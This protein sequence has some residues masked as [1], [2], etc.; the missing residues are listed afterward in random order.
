[1]VAKVTEDLNQVSK[2]FIFDQPNEWY[3]LLK[4]GTMGTVG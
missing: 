3:H 1:M 4:I 2:Y